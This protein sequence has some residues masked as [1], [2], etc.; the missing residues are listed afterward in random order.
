MF[1]KNTSPRFSKIKVASSSIS[2]Q[3]CLNPVKILLRIVAPVPFLRRTAELLEHLIPSYQQS[4]FDS[5]GFERGLAFIEDDRLS[6]SI[7]LFPWPKLFNQYKLGLPYPSG[8]PIQESSLLPVRTICLTLTV[9]PKKL[10]PIICIHM[11]LNI[12]NLSS[13]TN[14]L[15]RN[16]VK[17][18]V[19]GNFKSA[20][21]TLTYLSTP[22]LS[23]GL[24]PP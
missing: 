9:P 8:G 6:A 1:K 17:L 4:I 21:S 7:P 15:E 12:I 18:I 22:E 10:N 20:N 3:P 24:F 11:N 14:T 19:G 5:V 23:L 16:S 13:R 2:T